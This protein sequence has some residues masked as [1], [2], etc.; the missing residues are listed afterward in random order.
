MPKL[1]KDTAI[2]ENYRSTSLMYID[3]KIFN[4]V[5]ANQIQWQNKKFIYHN[6]VG[7]IRDVRMF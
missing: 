7:F 5:L 4:I 3:A 2:K 1:D 6:Q